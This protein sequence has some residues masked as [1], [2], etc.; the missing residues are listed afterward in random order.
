[1]NIVYITAL[2]GI[3]LKYKVKT[4]IEMKKNIFISNNP[5]HIK[6]YLKT[7]S[8]RAIGE[9]EDG[10]LYSGKPFIFQIGHVL[11]KDQI[12]NETILFL[13]EVQAFHIGLWLIRDCGVNNELAFGVLQDELLVH[14]NGLTIYNVRSDGEKKTHV[15]DVNELQD[16]IDIYSKHLGGAHNTDI[17]EC[18][19]FQAGLSRT[20]IAFYHLQTARS[21]EDLA[22]KVAHYCT[23]FESILST[24]TSELSHQVSERAALLL[25]RSKMDKIEIFKGIKNAYGVRSRIFHGERVSKKQL[26]DISKV[27]I[28]TDKI[29]RMLV[30]KLL[31][32]QDLTNMINSVD[33]ATIE[34]YMLNKLF[35]N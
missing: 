24:S 2:F 31:K 13:R 20:G 21:S 34:T 4:P 29:A 19:L 16:A 12:P 14:S 23:F 8:L 35:S 11:V 32:D 18:T 1:M 25:G 7:E 15:I 17:P 9:L 5:D 3:E 6:P 30:N 27:S 33:T 10:I 28:F 26:K 22:I